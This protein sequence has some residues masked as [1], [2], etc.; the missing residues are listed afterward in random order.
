MITHPVPRAGLAVL[1]TLAMSA[2]LKAVVLPSNFVLA[3]NA[4]KAA[5][6]FQATETR[7]QPQPQQMSH[8]YD[9]QHLI[10]YSPEHHK[11]QNLRGE[12]TVRASD[13]RTGWYVRAA[14]GGFLADDFD[15]GG[16]LNKQ[17]FSTAQ[18]SSRAGFRF[19]AAAGYRF[20]D[21]FN[22][23]FESGILYNE[24][25]QVILDDPKPT[26]SNEEGNSVVIGE[27]DIKDSDQFQVPMMLNALFYIPTGTPVV[28]PYIG[29]GVGG[30]FHWIDAQIS[31]PKHYGHTVDSFNLE[32]D[33][34]DFAY[35]AMAG[36]RFL[37]TPGERVNEL[38]PTHPLVEADLG[39]SWLADDVGVQSHAI[40]A[41]LSFTW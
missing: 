10:P 9:E 24:I 22:L 33:Q 29:G 28:R 21:W 20:A 25:H 17:K 27:D 5:S 30:M 2:P 3:G 37:I 34:L 39:Y 26:K 23:E 11:P 13:F 35:Q 32:I 12:N 8:Q 14:A 16:G 38:D 1:A 40:M 4:D 7:E 18:I 31:D 6:E 15:A 36:L 19:S 41:G